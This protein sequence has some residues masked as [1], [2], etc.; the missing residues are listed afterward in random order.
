MCKEAQFPEQITV[1][2]NFLT[3]M[4]GVD[5]A[6]NW[7]D[8]YKEMFNRPAPPA[9]P[10][11]PPPPPPPL[12]LSG[13]PREP[14]PHSALLLCVPVCCRLRSLASCAHAVADC[15]CREPSSRQPPSITWSRE[16]ATER[17]TPL[18]TRIRFAQRGVAASG[19]A[20]MHGVWSGVSMMAPSVSATSTV[21]V[22][23]RRLQR[24]PYTSRCLDDTEGS[25]YS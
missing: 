8:P 9:P 18:L 4:S 11:P 19:L 15:T 6:G 13:T 12:S 5:N 23:A 14:G 25:S 3:Y 21:F 17:R 7:V 20:R 2:D 24:A 1:V 22:F 10:A 16:S